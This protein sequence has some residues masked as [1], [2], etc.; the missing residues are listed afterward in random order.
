MHHAAFDNWCFRGAGS[1]PSG[2]SL[3]SATTQQEDG[4]TRAD[5]NI[6][7]GLPRTQCCACAVVCR[8]LQ[9]PSLARPSHWRSLVLTTPP[10]L[11][12]MLCLTIHCALRFTCRIAEAVLVPLLVTLLDLS[13][14]LVALVC[15]LLLWFWWHALNWTRLLGTTSFWHASFLPSLV[16]VYSGLRGEPGTAPRCCLSFR[17]S[18]CA[19]R[20]QACWHSS[21]YQQRHV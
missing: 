11:P 4:R 1:P 15:C 6:Q 2:Q 5:Y 17:H 18:C 8:F 7:R 19:H 20:M 12:T 14:T 21:S 9:R 16:L 10:V 13:V 3:T